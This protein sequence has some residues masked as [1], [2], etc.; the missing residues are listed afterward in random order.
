MP[1]TPGCTLFVHP[2]QGWPAEDYDM[3]GNEGAIPSGRVEF[4]YNPIIEANKDN[5]R[6]F[7]QAENIKWITTLRHPYSR[8]LSHYHHALRSGKEYKHITLH[9]LLTDLGGGF[10]RFIDNQMALWH[11]RLCHGFQ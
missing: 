10:H 11:R 7:I 9:Q 3:I 6:N 2:H 5:D 8:T 1:E 4:R